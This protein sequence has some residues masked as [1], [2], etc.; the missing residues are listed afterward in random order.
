MDGNNNPMVAM[1]M[2]FMPPECKKEVKAIQ[3]EAEKT[4]HWIKDKKCAECKDK[5]GVKGNTLLLKEEAAKI[6]LN[7]YIDWL[8]TKDLDIDKICPA[9]FRRKEIWEFYGKWRAPCVMNTEEF[10][11]IEDLCKAGEKDFPKTQK[12]VT[13]KGTA[14]F[15]ERATPPPMDCVSK[16]LKKCNHKDLGEYTDHFMVK[17]RNDPNVHKG[18]NMWVIGNE[19]FKTG[20]TGKF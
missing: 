14:V 17:M 20:C 10:T 2:S 3:A 12:C 16:A 1:V 18:K 13:D 8:A 4:Y 11:K 9:K 19:Y 15:K 6:A 7:A 5:G